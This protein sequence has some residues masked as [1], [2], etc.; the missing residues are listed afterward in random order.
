MRPKPRYSHQRRRA[1]LCVGADTERR[2]V[3]RL[4]VP[5]DA[6]GFAIGRT[7]SHRVWR[8]EG[9]IRAGETADGTTAAVL[10]ALVALLVLGCRAAVMADF[11]DAQ[12]IGRAT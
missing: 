7:K 9:R 1:R 4:L 10:A 5:G 2:Q 3:H 12:R 8:I 6:R 11:G